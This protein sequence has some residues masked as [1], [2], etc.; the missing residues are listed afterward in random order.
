MRCLYQAKQRTKA[1]ARERIGST[2]KLAEGY[3]DWER[4]LALAFRPHQL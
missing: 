1:A 2:D 4:L 3:D